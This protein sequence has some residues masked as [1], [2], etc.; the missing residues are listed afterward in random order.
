MDWNSSNG[1][2]IHC[3]T[4]AILEGLLAEYKQKIFAVPQ[5]DL[6]LHKKFHRLLVH[7]SSIH[8]ACCSLAR[9]SLIIWSQNPPKIDLRPETAFEARYSAQAPPVRCGS[10]SVRG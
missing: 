10:V 6:E 7:P 3:I 5:N 1:Y 2:L 8:F 4:L 9:C